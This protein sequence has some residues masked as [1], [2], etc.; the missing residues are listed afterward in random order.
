MLVA[1]NRASQNI[2]SWF[3]PGCWTLQVEAGF[4]HVEWINHVHMKS[5]TAH[6]NTPN[7]IHGVQG[8]VDDILWH[9]HYGT[10]GVPDARPGQGV[11]PVL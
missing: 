8:T 2:S 5:I 6:L 1:V 11:P 10:I 3:H 4:V 9:E 7:R